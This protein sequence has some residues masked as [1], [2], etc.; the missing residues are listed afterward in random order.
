VSFEHAATGAAQIVPGYGT[1]AEVWRDAAV[2]LDA[3][4]ED[5]FLF[6]DH[7]AMKIV[8]AEQIAAKLESLYSDD[9]FRRRVAAAGYRNATD[10]QYRWENIILRW[11]ELFQK[12]LE[13]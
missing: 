11:D 8:S 1:C 6:A 3:E 4:G 5:V 12:V 9:E 2:L 10:P 7:Y 13:G